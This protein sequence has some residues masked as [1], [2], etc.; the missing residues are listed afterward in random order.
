MK[1]IEGSY[2]WFQDIIKLRDKYGL[3]KWLF[4]I[5]RHGEKGDSKTT[6]SIL[7]EARIDE[8]LKQKIEATES[9]DLD[10]FTGGDGGGGSKGS[11]PKNG[12]PGP[13]DPRDA[14]ALVARLKILPRSDVD[15][16]LE[17][18]GISRVRDLDGSKLE[19]AKDYLSELE[20]GSAE[21]DASGE[22][23]PFL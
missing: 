1:V 4:E 7:P 18:F 19:A 3:D 5:E 11:K 10:A 22:V 21:T 12:K 14:G 9:H 16:F 15:A 13:I 8:D 2:R 17:K 6:Y 23:D 20:S